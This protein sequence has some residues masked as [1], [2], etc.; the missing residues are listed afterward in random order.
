MLYFILNKKTWHY[1]LSLSYC[2]LSN[3]QTAKRGW[4]CVAYVSSI[5]TLYLLRLDE[6][7][8]KI[9]SAYNLLIISNY[10][11]YEIHWILS[12]ILSLFDRLYIS[13]EKTLLFVMLDL[14]AAMYIQSHLKVRKELSKRS[15]KNFAKTFLTVNGP[16]QIFEIL[17]HT[18]RK[19]LPKFLKRTL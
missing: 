15:E 5:W 6:M 8:S 18:I 3:K 16:E 14:V 17:L 7:Y 2:S 10:H 1:L 4:C 9:G 12:K 11:V 13:K 19:P